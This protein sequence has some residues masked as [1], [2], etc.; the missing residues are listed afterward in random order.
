MD[1]KR[2]CRFLCDEVAVCVDRLQK[3]LHLL[4]CCED[5]LLYIYDIDT[6]MGGEC[7]LIKQHRSVINYYVVFIP[8]LL[9]F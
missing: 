2:R 3:K 9:M 8:S 6:A 5:A 4:V 1:C 7:N